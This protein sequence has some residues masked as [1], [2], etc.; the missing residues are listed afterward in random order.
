MS[1]SDRTSIV[2]RVQEIINANPNGITSQEAFERA[3]AE[4]YKDDPTGLLQFAAAAV[5]S[6]VRGLRQRTYDLPDSGEHALFEI[7]ETIGIKT[8]DGDLFIARECAL[9]GQVRQWLREG[10]QHHSAQKLRFKRA[11]KELQV[12]QGE[13]DDLPWWSARVLLCGELT[14]PGGDE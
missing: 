13:P 10:D 2:L 9:L 3:L 12:L 4:R 7:P 6:T 5:R 14:E 11:L 8:P 1:K